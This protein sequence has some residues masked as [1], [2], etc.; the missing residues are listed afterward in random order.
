MRTVLT[1][2]FTAEL[3]RELKAYLALCDEALA[4]T[5]LEGQLLAQE[6]GYQ[7]AEFQA[8][9]K[10]LIPELQDISEK[11]RNSRMVWLQVSAQEREQCQ[12]VKLLFQR[13]QCSLMRL[14][15]L[16][17]EN[18]QAMLKRGLVPVRHIPPPA[19]QRPNYVANIYQRNSV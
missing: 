8:K 12:E 16:D 15:Q 11:L 19:A 6:T 14:L 2:E 7:S 1:A 17:R 13:I 10:R 9:R 3:I 5:V 4:L 18:Q